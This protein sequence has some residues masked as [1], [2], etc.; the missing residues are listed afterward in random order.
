MGC[1]YVF[2]KAAGTITNIDL[3]AAL[4][5]AKDKQNVVW[6]NLFQPTADELAV[7]KESL[8]LHELT[9]ED[10]ESARVRPKVE[11][12]DDHL[13]IVFKAL[14]F[15][16]AVEEIDRINLNLLL[17]KNI[18]ITAYLEPIDSIDQL[19]NE[20]PK[21]PAIMQR[22]ADFLLYSVLDCVV[23]DYFPFMDELD[24]AT[25]RLEGEIFEKFNRKLSSEIF[26]L[27]LKVTHLR[28]LLGPKR[29]MLNNLI[30]RPHS[31]INPKTQVY[32]RDVYDHIIRINDYL[33]TYREILQGAM[34]S[35]LTQMSNR[36]NDI[37]KT[38]SAVA[39]TMLPL[40]II[41][42]IYGTNFKKLPGAEGQY[43][44]WLFMAAMG[45]VFLANLIYF[46]KKKWF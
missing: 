1:C 14:N 21:R 2:H 23:D 41:A 5:A 12:F 20:I 17:F 10:L 38:L 22:G 13:Y 32:L 39:T 29:E 15:R 8:N 26:Q 6:I 24:E 27:K 7:L 34:D 4:E 45:L 35:Y 25:D 37:M 16:E 31:L 19:V 33:E 3:A 18:L 30:S 44:F 9:V 46:K 11:E 40:G 28:R 36:M 42:G 43:S